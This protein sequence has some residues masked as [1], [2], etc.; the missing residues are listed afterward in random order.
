[1]QKRTTPVEILLWESKNLIFRDFHRF[2]NIPLRISWLLF[3]EYLCHFI[4][5]PEKSL[6]KKITRTNGLR[7]GSL[8]KKGPLEKGPREKNLRK[9]GRRKNAP[10]TSVSHSLVYVGLWGKHGEKILDY[11]GTPR[12]TTAN[13]LCQHSDSKGFSYSSKKIFVSVWFAMITNYIC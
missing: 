12:V 8:G 3:R 5:I 10:R 11:G 1:M 13:F 9:N 7:K 4:Q 6:Q 2:F